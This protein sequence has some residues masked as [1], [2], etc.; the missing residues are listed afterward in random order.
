MLNI[1]W[2]DTLFLIAVVYAL[3]EYVKTLANNKLGQWARLISI[4]FGF[5]MVYFAQYAPEIVKLGFIVG[6]GASGIYDFRQGNTITK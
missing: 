1:N 2:Q 4:A 5:G 3:T 6:V